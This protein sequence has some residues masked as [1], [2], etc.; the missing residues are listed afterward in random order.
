MSRDLKVFVLSK[1]YHYYNS[2]PHQRLKLIK[3]LD[4]VTVDRLDS[5]AIA[6]KTKKNCLAQFF[7]VV[8]RNVLTI[9]MTKWCPQINYIRLVAYR[10]FL[11]WDQHAWCM[12]LMAD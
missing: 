3:I 2:S 5:Q 12:Y 8:P 4:K 7:K 11:L 1:L 9:V 10:Y 6:D